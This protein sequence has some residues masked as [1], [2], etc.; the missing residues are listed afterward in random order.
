MVRFIGVLILGLLTGLPLTASPWGVGL[1]SESWSQVD[2]DASANPK[3]PPSKEPGFE[4]LKLQVPGITT[5]YLEEP[6]FLFGLISGAAETEAN[7]AQAR[8]QA[9]RDG[10]LTYS[11]AYGQPAPLPEGRWNRWSIS[12]GQGSVDGRPELLVE[13]LRI[14]MDI[15]TAPSPFLLPGAYWMPS[16]EISGRSVKIRPR[17]GTTGFDFSTLAVPFFFHAGY[18]APLFPWVTVEARA[19]WDFVS[20]GLFSLAALS[21]K[22]GLQNYTHGTALGF[23]ATFGTSWIGGYVDVSS[24]T[25]PLWNFSGYARRYAGTLWVAGVRIDIVNLM[26]LFF[27]ET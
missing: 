17:Q 5:W 27:P 9:R 6:G 1:Q 3:Y 11:W 19:G 20:W 4:H 22:G 16:A 15:V 25:E 13:Y 26:E 24:R 10:S 23:K 21:E 2:L 12:T 14:N 8:D 18:Q 7:E